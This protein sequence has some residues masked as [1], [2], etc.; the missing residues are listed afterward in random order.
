MSGHHSFKKLQQ[1][2][3]RDPLRRARMDEKREAYNVLLKLSELGELRRERGVTQTELAE[4][5]GVSQ[6][7]VSKIE[8]AAGKAVEGEAAV[9]R[10]PEGL[11]LQL[12]TLAGY[13]E[14]L[15]GHLEL[16]A[17]FSGDPDRESDVAV[18]VASE[19]EAENGG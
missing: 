9:S 16:H 2:I 15:G 1:E 3:E 6:A 7:A 8:V 19:G 10:E 11:S 4:H 14:A 12:G 5:L 13:I 17:V 18:A